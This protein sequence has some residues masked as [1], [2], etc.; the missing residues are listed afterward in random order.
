MAT[1]Q[2]GAAD[3]EDGV[4]RIRV[5]QANADVWASP[6][7]D[8]ADAR[9]EVDAIKVGGD[10]NNRFGI[11]CRVSPGQFYI[12]LV[13]SDGYYGIGKV[14]DNQY[15][16]LGSAALLQNE[17]IPKGSA[18]LHLRVDCVED[19]LRLFVNGEKIAEVRDQDLRSGDIGL[20]AG[21]YTANGADILFDNFQVFQP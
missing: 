17:F 2:N 3:Y 14:I 15:Q 13:S 4:Y 18:Y 21:A 7:L 11:L 19:L 10:R 20:A 12:F 6:G 5:N 16:L 1:S 9:I 8:L